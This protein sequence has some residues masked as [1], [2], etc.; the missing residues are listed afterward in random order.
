MR[1]VGEAMRGMRTRAWLATA[2]LGLAIAMWAAPVHAQDTAP[3]DLS[4]ELEA[5]ATALDKQII[6]PVC[7]GETL[8]QSQAT[9]AKQMRA[10]VRER[11]AAGQSPDEITA[12]FVSVYGPSVLAQPPTSGVA[13]AVWLVPPVALAIGIAVLVLALRSMRRTN[14]AALAMAQTVGGGAG[15]VTEDTPTRVDDAPNA[16][17][18]TEVAEP[19]EET[20]TS[21]QKADT[22]RIPRPE[23]ETQIE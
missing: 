2:W 6:C 23:D 7:P 11:L 9:L 5:T 15:P 19:E 17:D 22:D 14:A 21:Y 1:L 16:N 4:P 8:N 12:Y 18:L 3:P 20:K 10:I 13:L